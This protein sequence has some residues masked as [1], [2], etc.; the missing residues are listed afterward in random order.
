MAKRR[1]LKNVIKG[2]IQKQT[3]FLLTY[4]VKK[5]LVSALCE[6]VEEHMI[7]ECKFCRKASEILK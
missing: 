3:E 6:A 1:L 7:E 2:V 4:P 5:E